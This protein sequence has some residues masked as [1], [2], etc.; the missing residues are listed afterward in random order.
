MVR[1]TDEK[2][3]FI[4]LATA[5]ANVVKKLFEADHDAGKHQRNGETQR[6]KNSRED[7]RSALADI[8]R[9]RSST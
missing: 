6:Q 5:I 1:D 7:L 9:D 2:D 3:T 4:P 8:M